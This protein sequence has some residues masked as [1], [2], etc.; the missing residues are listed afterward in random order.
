MPFFCIIPC[1]LSLSC[2]HDYLDRSLSNWDVQNKWRGC[3]GWFVCT[4]AYTHT[5]LPFPSTH[6]PS[7]LSPDTPLAGCSIS[8]AWLPQAKQG[9]ECKM[10]TWL[11]MRII[12]GVVRWA[13][14]AAPC[15]LTAHSLDDMSLLLLTAHSYPLIIYTHTG[16]SYQHAKQT[17]QKTN[18]VLFYWF[19]LFLFSP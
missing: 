4:E 17:N 12:T 18:L 3:A 15:H 8:H 16:A 9:N 5:P 2:N 1:S 6:T 7:A 19:V 13:P 14:P 11:K 10:P